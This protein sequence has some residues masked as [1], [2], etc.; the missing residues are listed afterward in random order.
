MSDAQ[1][2][3]LGA[4]LRDLSRLRDVAVIVARH[5]F[6]E[7]L[8]HSPLGLRLLGSSELPEEDSALRGASAADR[9]AHLLSELGPTFIKLGQIL[10]MRRDLLPA[11]MIASLE[12]LQDDARPLPFEDIR[13]AVE[14][15]LGAPL[16]DL[17]RDFEAEPLATASI[18][19]THLATTHAGDRTVVKVQ[20]PG[21]EK[22]LRGDLDLLFLAAQVLEASIDEAQLMGTS[23][24]V[25]EFERGLLR[26]LDFREEL[27]NLL[28]ARQL[29]DPA[30]QVTVPRPYPELSGRRVLTMQYFEG[31]SLRSLE[32]G[33][34]RAKHAISE[35]VH[36]ACKQ[37]LIDGFFHGDPHSGNILIDAEGTLCMIDLGLA[38]S[39]SDAQREDLV[40]LALAILSADDGAIA[41]MLIKMGTP[42][43]RV[44]LS[45]LRAEVERLRTRYL[46]VESLGDVDSTGLA[47]ELVEAAQRFRIKLAPEYSILSKAAA[48]IEGLV[49]HLDPEVDLAGIARPYVQ[50]VMLG[51]LSPGSFMRGMAGEAGTLANLARELPGHLDQI[52]HDVETGNLQIRALSPALDEVPNLLHQ[53]GGR[54]GLT[55]LATAL[56]L[57]A[58]IL[59]SGSGLAGWQVLLGTSAALGAV[60]A[61]VV[62]FWW[63]LL[64]R[65]K[66]LRLR[67]LVR[68][69]RR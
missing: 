2:S 63:H 54:I 34:E 69:F 67:P 14:A 24:V 9:F 16:A 52:L 15:E 65:G 43:Q 1:P 26:E 57:A 36:S 11:E 59:L 33:T 28:R 55:G 47:Q 38:G 50:Q 23:D 60:L 17:F 66:P 44:H 58:A 22:T 61:W 68:L 21:I 20:R 6:G 41:R 13:E 46:D 7:L 64:G 39:L 27:G 40:A 53:L 10:S 18:A 49:R 42:T 12:K 56:T 25:E 8:Q 29:L 31:A 4:A 51:R 35:V 32:P 19:Q 48:T 45:E 37:V 3:L 5:G 30:H 62:L